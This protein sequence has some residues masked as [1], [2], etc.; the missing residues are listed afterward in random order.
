MFSLA[1]Y[2][3]AIIVAQTAYS[4]IRCNGLLSL[5]FQFWGFIFTQFIKSL[6]KYINTIF[7]LRGNTLFDCE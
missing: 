6:N 4:I 7:L 3:F 2:R 1:F 5:K